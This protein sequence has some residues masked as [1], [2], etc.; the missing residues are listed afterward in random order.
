MAIIILS[1]DC[2]GLYRTNDDYIVGA[3]CKMLK[4]SI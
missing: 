3:I 1:H 2:V 4:K